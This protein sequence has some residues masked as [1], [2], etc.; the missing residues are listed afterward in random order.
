MNL[1]FH[2][3]AERHAPSHGGIA[4]SA[5][6]LSVFLAVLCFA[7]DADAARKHTPPATPLS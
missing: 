4:L 5:L 7:Q 2:R 6:A 3:K 1:F